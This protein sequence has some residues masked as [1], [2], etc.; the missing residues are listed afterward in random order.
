LSTAMCPH[1]LNNLYEGGRIAK[2][3]KV[4]NCLPAGGSGMLDNKTAYFTF[5]ILTCPFCDNILGAV[6]SSAVPVPSSQS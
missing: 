3:E 5:A 6:N 4:V 2:G 1:C